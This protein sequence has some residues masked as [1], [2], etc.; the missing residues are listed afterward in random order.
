MRR[1]IGL[2]MLTLTFIY[3]DIETNHFGGNWLPQS[4]AELAC[5]MVALIFGGLGCYL[6]I[7]AKSGPRGLPGELIRERCLRSWCLNVTRMERV[8]EWHGWVVSLLHKTRFSVAVIY[9]VADDGSWRVDGVPFS[10]YRKTDKFY[11]YIWRKWQ[12]KWRA[13]DLAPPKR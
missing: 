3:V 12:I 13:G 4:L 11:S 6:L 5:D 9:C 2:L 7:R 8:T 10:G 1:L